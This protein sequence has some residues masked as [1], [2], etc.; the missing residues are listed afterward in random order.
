MFTGEV[1]VAGQVVFDS[2]TLGISSA[3]N[4]GTQVEIRRRV[5]ACRRGYYS[6]GRFW[7]RNRVWQFTRTVFGAVVQGGLLTGLT[8]Q[9]LTTTQERALDKVLAGFARKILGG[10][11]CKKIP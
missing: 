5:L 7:A 2:I 6:M 8:T 11:A 3:V 1:P 4:G 9:I 10:D